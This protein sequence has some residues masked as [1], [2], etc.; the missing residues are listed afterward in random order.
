MNYFDRLSLIILKT[1]KCIIIK[2]IKP[3]SVNRYTNRKKHTNEYKKWRTI[4]D[5]IFS[6]LPND[7]IPTDIDEF[8]IGIEVG[9]Y[10]QFDLDNTLK[11]YIDALER[12]YGFNDN[13]IKRI[14][15]RKVD[16]DTNIDDEY[17]KIYL[18]DKVEYNSEKTSSDNIY[19][20]DV[21][22]EIYGEIKDILS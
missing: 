18:L 8:D 20:Y 3:Y 1:H 5:N 11:A 4:V 16:V 12:R 6:N 2:G 21:P 17:L 14:L 7:F 13:K 9:A 19:Q 15:A 22:G 10:K